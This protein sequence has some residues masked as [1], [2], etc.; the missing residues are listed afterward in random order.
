MVK[1]RDR[2][3]MGWVSMYEFVARGRS[4]LYTDHYGL[5]ILVPLASFIR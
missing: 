2:K 5:N 4:V 1:V 3:R